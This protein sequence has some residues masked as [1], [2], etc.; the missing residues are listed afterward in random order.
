MAKCDKANIDSELFLLTIYDYLF[1]FILL[2]SDLII[3]DFIC[4]IL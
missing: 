4:A 3:Y 1:V 2:R